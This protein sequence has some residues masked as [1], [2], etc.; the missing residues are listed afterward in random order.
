MVP[1][2]P[3][4]YREIRGKTLDKI[5]QRIRL[6]RTKIRGMQDTSTDNDELANSIQAGYYIKNNIANNNED[7]F[8]MSII[9]TISANSYKELIW[10]KQQMSDFL[11]S[12]DMHVGECNFQQEAALSSV[13]PL[14]N[15]ESNLE[16]KMQR[17][18]LTSGAASTYMFT[19]FGLSDDNGKQKTTVP[20]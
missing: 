6:N 8:Y 1:V 5:A 10:R 7:L 14:L 19:S 17:N 4:N 11:K 18:I 13:M 15:M 9:I 12:M 3:H 2:V 20:V 16:K